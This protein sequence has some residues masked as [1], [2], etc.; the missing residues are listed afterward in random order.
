MNVLVGLEQSIGS[1]DQKW[2][3]NSRL[4]EIEVAAENLRGILKECGLNA[5]REQLIALVAMKWRDVTTS[6]HRLH[7]AMA[8]E[9]FVDNPRNC[10]NITSCAP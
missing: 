7:R 2:H 1:V 6:A 8:A 3:E 9:S 5:S 4:A 10:D